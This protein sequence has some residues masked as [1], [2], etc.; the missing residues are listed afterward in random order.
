MSYP[1][2]VVTPTGI[3]IGQL[4]HAEDAALLAAAYGDGSIIQA[5]GIVVWKEGTEGVSAADNYDN[6]RDVIVLRLRGVAGAGANLRRL[7]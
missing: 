1:F 4:L 7:Q 3:L 5:K 6:T 2:E